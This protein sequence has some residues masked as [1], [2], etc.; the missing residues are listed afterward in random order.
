MDQWFSDNTNQRFDSYGWQVLSADGH[1]HEEIGE[2]LEQA[3]SDSKR[4]SIIVVRQL[5][6]LE[7]QIKK[8]PPR[9]ME[10]H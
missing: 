5:S 8:E 3:R 2:V 9:L 1:D 10:P 7:R 4:P 6:V